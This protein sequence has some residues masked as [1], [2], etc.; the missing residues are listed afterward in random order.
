MP[1]NIK[2]SFQTFLVSTILVIG[3]ELA[4][5][6]NLIEDPPKGIRTVVIDAG[7]GGRDPGAVGKKGKEK[8]IALSIAL[9]VGNYIEENVP[10]VKVIYTRKKD[11]FVELMD[12]AEIA[13]QAEA[14]LFISIHVNAVP[15]PTARGTL[16]LVLGQHRS[17][18]NLDVAMR[19]NSVILLEDDYETRYEGF[20]PQSTESYIMFSMMQKTYFKQS[21]E[22]GDFVQDQFRER[23]GRKDLGVRQQG[24]LVLAQ[25]AMPGVM[26][27]TGFIS[28]PEEEKYLMTT[29]GQEIIASAIYR[30]FKEYKEEIDRRSN[31]TVVVPEESEPVSDQPA[32]TQV[33]IDPNQVIFSIQ[34]A[35]SKNKIQADPSSFKGYQNVIVIADGRWYKYM[36][37]QESSYHIA[38]EKCKE[39]KADYPD[40]FVV[41]SKNS[42]IIPLK[43]ALMEIN[44]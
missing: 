3:F 22:F 18:E 23:A 2:R 33:E 11:V 12:R 6:G 17:D 15:G 36:V 25:T 29:Y 24:L 27:E 7:H 21:I 31:L 10:D 34:L 19:E 38:L 44:R 16:T 32:T 26:V 4:A 1:I 28:N 13:N 37:G 14:D 40:A 9:K 41:A 43:D 35:S 8:D 30:G 39:I 5:S 20:N 42:K